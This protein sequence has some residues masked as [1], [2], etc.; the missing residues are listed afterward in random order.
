MDKFDLSVFVDSANRQCDPKAIDF[1]DCLKFARLF[2][3]LQY[4]SL[5][6][7]KHDPDHQNWF[8]HFTQ[9]VYKIND[10]LDDYHHFMKDHSN[11]LKEI[12]EYLTKRKS[13]K[14]CHDIKQCQYSYRHHRADFGDEKDNDKLDAALNLY[15]STLDSLHFY[16]FHLYH[17]GMRVNTTDI[18]QHNDETEIDDWFFD[19]EF[20]KIKES[21]SSRRHISISFERFNESSGSNSKFN[22][23]IGNNDLT[24]TNEA[25]NDS[26]GRTYLDAI[27]QH[28]NKMKVDQKILDKLKDYL[29]AQ[30]YCTESVDY[31]IN[32]DNGLN[33]NISNYIDDAK[34]VQHIID[35]M[36]DS[37]R[38]SL[39]V[40]C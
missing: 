15:C 28:I 13:V 5:L 1:K 3:C 17:I 4:Y 7:V 25:M 37:R 31:D 36:N 9:S 40:F 2:S 11:Y 23:N 29:A 19:V 18:T 6:N 16:V 24:V 33:G 35:F 39:S 21:I 30:D 27:Y 10:L 8:E 14:Q 34:C 32:N 12:I 22:I 26:Q 38:M 20:G